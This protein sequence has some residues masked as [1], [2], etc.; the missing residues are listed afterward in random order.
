MPPPLVL[1]LMSSSGFPWDPVGTSTPFYIPLGGGNHRGFHL[2][3]FGFVPNS[4]R[5]RYWQMIHIPIEIPTGHN[6]TI[7]V[8]P[9]F[10]AHLQGGRAGAFP[11]ALCSVATPSSGLAS[12]SRRSGGRSGRVTRRVGSGRG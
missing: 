9:S 2:F 7:S 10:A 12:E 1:S 8:F 5:V 3:L 11:E 6:T 4:P